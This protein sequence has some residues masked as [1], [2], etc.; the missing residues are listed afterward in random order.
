MH[1]SQTL[2]LP[3]ASREPLHETDSPR[4]GLSG[5]HG[6]RRVEWLHAAP[7]LAAAKSAFS[8]AVFL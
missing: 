2:D 7:V 3:A 8:R 4:V 1:P 5:R 6:Q